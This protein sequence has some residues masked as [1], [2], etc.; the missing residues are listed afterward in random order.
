MNLKSVPTPDLEAELARRHAVESLG[1]EPSSRVKWTCPGC[2]HVV[3]AG[4]VWVGA[5]FDFGEVWCEGCIPNVQRAKSRGD[6]RPMV[7]SV[8]D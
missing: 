4:S 1:C 7:K 8:G 6:P 3:Y 2:G 5:Y